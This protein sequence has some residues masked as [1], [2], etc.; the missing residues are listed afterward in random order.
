[1][2]PPQR[3]EVRLA[4]S[5]LRF[6]ASPRPRSAPR[7]SGQVARQ[8]RIGTH[9]SALVAAAHLAD[10]SRSTFSSALE[11]KKT[12]TVHVL[13][14]YVP[15]PCIVTGAKVPAGLF[16]RLGEEWR[17][18]MGGIDSP[19]RSGPR[20]PIAAFVENHAGTTDDAMQHGQ[21]ALDA[22]RSP[23]PTQ[24]ENRQLHEGAGVR[25]A[26]GA[27]TR[28]MLPPTLQIPM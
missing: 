1:M 6:M 11:L 13:H 3:L 14:Q 2:R 18:P 27:S 26:S 8:A 9:Q 10:T 16:R 20:F 25:R 19:C 28:A 24:I 22:R 7:Y 15:R 12:R 23:Q 17:W 5:S 4:G 21:A